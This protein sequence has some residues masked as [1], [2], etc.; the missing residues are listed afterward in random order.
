M[1]GEMLVTR[2]PEYAPVSDETSPTWLTPRIRSL[3]QRPDQEIAEALGVSRNT[4]YQQRYRRG[5]PRF[6]TKIE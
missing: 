6:G 3:G 4:V 2:E 5:I 1:Q